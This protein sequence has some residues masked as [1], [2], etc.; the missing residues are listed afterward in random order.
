MGYE[1]IR[2][3]CPNAKKCKVW[4][5]P[6][7]NKRV[8]WNT[9]LFSFNIQSNTPIHFIA[10]YSWEK[11]KLR[12]VIDLDLDRA[13]HSL[14][15]CFCWG[16][17]SNEIKLRIC[18]QNENTQVQAAQKKFRHWSYQLWTPTATLKS[19]NTKWIKLG[20]KLLKNHDATEKL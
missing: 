6:Q 17:K 12:K 14:K 16:E 19:H 2:D 18:R 15:V 3:P 20:I 5:S 9:P 8:S 13:L 7:K 1:T 11:N 4:F 10:H